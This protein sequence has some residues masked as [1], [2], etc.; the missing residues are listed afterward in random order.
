M[1]DKVVIPGK[2]DILD[3]KKFKVRKHKTAELDAS[4]EIL[5]DA[6]A[7]NGGYQVEKLSVDGLPAKMDDGTPIRWLNNFAIRKNG[8][9]IS[10]RYSVTIAGLG[11]S[12][13]VILD[14]KGKLYYYTGTVVKDTIELTDGDP[15]VGQAP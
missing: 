8:Q 5:D 1:P 15:G 12:N 14:G 13:V 7:A 9:Y 3:K 6:A 2:V 4:I 10:Q 11:S